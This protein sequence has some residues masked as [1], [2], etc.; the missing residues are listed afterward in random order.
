MKTCAKSRGISLGVSHFIPVFD[1]ESML[2][3]L[4]KS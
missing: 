1:S 2:N 3:I 4:K